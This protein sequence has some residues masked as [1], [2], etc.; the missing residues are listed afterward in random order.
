MIYYEIK[1][2]E[3]KTEDTELLSMFF[4]TAWR[5]ALSR[6]NHECDGRVLTICLQGK[7]YSVYRKLKN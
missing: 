4:G 7:K 1:N 6:L 2:E 5:L 3:G